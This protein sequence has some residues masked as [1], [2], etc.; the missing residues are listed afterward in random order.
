MWL[1]TLSLPNQM[2]IDRYIGNNRNKG[3]W[4][5][6]SP[7]VREKSLFHVVRIFVIIGYCRLLLQMYSP[8]STLSNYIL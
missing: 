6:Q 4:R 3:G 5:N 1:H 7:Q 8:G 2:F